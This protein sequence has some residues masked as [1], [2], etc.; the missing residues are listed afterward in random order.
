MHY[1]V[2]NELQTHNTV[3]ALL[4]SRGKPKEAGDSSCSQAKIQPAKFTEA[5]HIS[6][7]YAPT[8]SLSHVLLPVTWTS[9]HALKDLIPQMPPRGGEE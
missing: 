9:I 7:F 2:H 6:L 5:F 1:I 8:F 3:M 4:G